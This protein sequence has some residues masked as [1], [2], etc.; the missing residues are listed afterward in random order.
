[1]QK[2][3]LKA[4]GW[5]QKCLLSR[6]RHLVIGNARVRNINISALGL[7]FS[8]REFD[9]FINILHF[10][11]IKIQL[12]YFRTQEHLLF[13]YIELRALLLMIFVVIRLRWF[14]YIAWYHWSLINL[15]FRS[16]LMILTFLYEG[17]SK[18]FESWWNIQNLWRHIFNGWSLYAKISFT[19]SYFLLFLLTN[20]YVASSISNL[21]CVIISD[22]ICLRLLFNRCGFVIARELTEPTW[23]YWRQRESLY[24]VKLELGLFK[25]CNYSLF[26]IQAWGNRNWI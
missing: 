9:N 16:I 10:I 12:V 2:L 18:L 3:R 22:A 14:L 1:M 7:N 5:S 13:S 23:A 21:D 25:I 24:F 6:E 11:I 19:L 26:L 20:H 8:T 17:G 4:W 15:E